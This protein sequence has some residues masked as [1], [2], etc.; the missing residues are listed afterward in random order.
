MTAAEAPAPGPGPG[1]RSRAL[2]RDLRDA[3][4]GTE[5]DYTEGTL[6]RAILLLA[7]PMMLEM[8][9]ESVFAVVDVYFVSS[10]GASAVATVGLTESLL[11]FVYA[12]GIG[13]SMG[14]TALVSRRIGEKDPRGAAEAAVQCV[15]V[16]VV[17]SVPFA[18]A[19]IVFARDLL[20]LMGAD[21]WTLE[22]GYRYATWMLGGNVVIMLLFILNAV[23]RGAGDAAIAMR[24]LWIANIINIVLD[25]VLIFGWGPFPA[26]GVEG[27]AVA[28][29]IG[30]GTGVLLQVWVLLRG[31][32]HIRVLPSQLRLRADVMLRLVRTSLGGIG[33]FV[34]AT[35]SWVG[36]VRMVA[37]FGSEAVAG[38]TIAVRVF[39]FTLLPS[40][41]LSNAAATLVGQNLGAR[42]PERAERAV[43]ITGWINMGFLLAV[44]VVYL[45]TAEPLIRLFTDE[46][47]VVATGAEALRIWALGYPLYAWALVMPQAFNGAGDTM[48]PTRINLFCYWLFQ[49]PVAYALTFPL[50]AG[51]TGVFWAVVVAETLAGLVG[52]VL[53]R[54]GKW[55]E[56]RV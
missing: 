55:K 2:L 18:I 28:T 13:L 15:V 53:F 35:T 47:A 44:G 48:T 21:A 23:F 45:L 56:T 4:R 32:K 38:Y 29:N 19:G 27:A 40:W 17:A 41:G 37:E 20:A 52:I 31:A 34:I 30:R 36:L 11:T 16:A 5:M 46:P 6:G 54:R 7:V 3:I 9:M 24:V 43:W 1:A 39:I 26:M 25:P 12:I 42:R 22:H 14:A 10:L 51:K 50:E 8:V 33:Q 49:I